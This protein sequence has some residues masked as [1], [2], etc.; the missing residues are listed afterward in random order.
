MPLWTGLRVVLLLVVAQAPARAVASEVQPFVDFESGP[1]FPGYDDVRIPG[2]V[3]TTF[4][5]TQQLQAPVSPYFRARAGV[6]IGRHEV[7]AFFA[8]LTI[9]ST[10][11]VPYDVRFVNAVF[12][13]NTFLVGSWTFDSYRVTYRY[14]VVDGEEWQVAVGASAKVR[15]AAISLSGGGLYQV[16]SDTG[17]V[18][19]LSLKVAWTFA[20]R[21]ALLLDGD[22][23][24]GPQGRAEDVFLGVRYRFGEAVDGRIGYRILEGGADNSN[25]YN[26][27]LVNFL[28]IGFDVRL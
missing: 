11:T 18:P 8:P 2:D 26:F 25:V 13:A 3:G 23:L 27:A 28:A 19:L 6:R 21:W 16:K 20:G 5:L 7:Y 24:V 9:R 4:S 17:F 1:A 12:P 22:G 10:G 15:E 14:Y